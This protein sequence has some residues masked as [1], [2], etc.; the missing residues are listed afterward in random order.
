MSEPPAE[1]EVFG[2]VT[3]ADVELLWPN[4]LTDVEENALPV[5]LRAAHT[6]CVAYLRGRNPATADTLRVAQVAQ[7]R[8]LARLFTVGDGGTM[9]GIDGG[10]VRVFPMDW[11]VKA[12]LRPYRRRRYVR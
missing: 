12:L 3:L 8:A 11:T 6:E 4:G 10:E 5:Y 9:T 2:W 1:P 7:A